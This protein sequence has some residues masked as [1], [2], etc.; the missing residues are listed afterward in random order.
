M[1]CWNLLSPPRLQLNPDYRR[2]GR[3]KSDF[4]AVGGS[5]STREAVNTIPQHGCAAFAR[6]KT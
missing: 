3:A 4:A 6:S 2:W 5:V 1:D